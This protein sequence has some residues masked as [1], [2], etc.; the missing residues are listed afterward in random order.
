MFLFSISVV[1]EI[2]SGF[3]LGILNPMLEH[4][5]SKLTHSCNSRWDIPNHGPVSLKDFCGTIL[6]AFGLLITQH[7]RFQTIRSEDTLFL[8]HGRLH[9]HKLNLVGFR[10]ESSLFIR[11]VLTVNYFVGEHLPFFV[12]F[13]SKLIYL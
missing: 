6:D 12:Y 7:W 1:Q 10:N 8:A 2:W 5:L 4:V 9:C 13:L 11:Q 3:V